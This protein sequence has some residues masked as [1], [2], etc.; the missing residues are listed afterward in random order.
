MNQSAI[1][2]ILNHPLSQPDDDH[3][4]QALHGAAQCPSGQRDRPGCQALP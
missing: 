4:G 1:D 2:E 3:A